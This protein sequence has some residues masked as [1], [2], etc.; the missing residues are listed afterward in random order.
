MRPNPPDP[1]SRTSRQPETCCDPPS[2]A[3]F[4]NRQLRGN[5]YRIRNRLPLNALHKQLIEMYQRDRP[6]WSSDQV[7]FVALRQLNRLR[8]STKP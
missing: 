3:S 6:G 7:Y 2:P 4:P 5:R 1:S 8:R